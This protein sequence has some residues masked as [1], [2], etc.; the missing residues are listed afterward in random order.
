MH[1]LTL[2]TY[3]NIFNQTFCSNI[4]FIPVKNRAEAKKVAELYTSMKVYPEKPLCK[5]IEKLTKD[6]DTYTSTKIFYDTAKDD[7]PHHIELVENDNELIGA[8]SL[9]YSENNPV[10]YIDFMVETPQIRKKKISKDFLLAIAERICDIGNSN[11]IKFIRWSS[12]LKNPLAS[13]LYKK[14]IKNANTQINLQTNSLIYTVE[15]DKFK[16]SIDEYKRIH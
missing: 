14:R 2:N 11:N 4:K 12:N 16:N 5:F 3:K 7:T 9:N 10:A 15:L 6:L 1:I 8:Y 13:N